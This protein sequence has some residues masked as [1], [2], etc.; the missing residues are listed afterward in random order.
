MWF[1]TVKNFAIERIHDEEYLWNLSV[2]GNWIKFSWLGWCWRFWRCHRGR[3][4]GHR[5]LGICDDSP[6]SKPPIICLSQ[7]AVDLFCL[8]FYEQVAFC[9]AQVRWRG[10]LQPD[11]GPSTS[12]A[13]TSRHKWSRVEPLE[14]L[15]GWRSVS[16]AIHSPSETCTGPEI[17]EVETC[18]A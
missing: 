9:W 10:N 7:L 11:T 16:P 3:H 14:I 1:R 17:R 4:Q 12:K 18:L 2:V 13:Y 6:W 5:R 8:A 15:L